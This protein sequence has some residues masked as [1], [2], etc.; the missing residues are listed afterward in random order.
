VSL[1][2]TRRSP[3]SPIVREE[4]QLA[5]SHGELAA[6]VVM[7]PG[8]IQRP[9]TI[10]ICLPGMTYRR[11]YFDLH[12]SGHDSYSFAE[13]LAN[14]GHVVVG[15]DNLGTG[16][17]SRPDSRVEVDLEMIATASA[18]ASV[19]VRERLTEGTLVAGEPKHEVHRM[20]GVG[21][22]MGGGVLVVQQARS[23]SFDAVAPLG[24]T[25]QALAGIYEPGA[26]DDELTFEQRAARAREHIP[27]KLWGR[28]WNELEPYFAISRDGFAELF[29]AADVPAAV[30]EADT[31]AETVVP[32]QAAIDMIVPHLGARYA[33]EVAVPVLLAYGDPDLSPDPRAEVQAYSSSDDLT[34]VLLGDSAHCHNLASSR[35]VLWER[36]AVWFEG[37]A[38]AGTPA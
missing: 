26:D 31:R 1:T 15:F 13:F 21:H 28:T 3:P 12:F 8:R 6:T 24:Y 35:A 5:V 2:E 7:A 33:A 10:V 32:R 17:S 14:R 20:V 9:T 18:E 27:Q 22:S 38:V 34:L 16:D 29:Y 4:L 11:S 19:Q 25:T 37:L 23:A 36:I 30:I